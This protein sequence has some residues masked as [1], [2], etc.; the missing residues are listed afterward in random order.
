V[1]LRDIEKTIP[2]NIAREQTTNLLRQLVRIPS[3]NP[4]GDRRD[5]ADFLT[6]TIAQRGFCLAN[7]KW[8]KIM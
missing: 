8:K 1:A 7:S 5:I 6:Q 2:Q 4:S 3:A